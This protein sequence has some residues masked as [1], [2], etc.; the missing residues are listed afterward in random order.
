MNAEK[1]EKLLI[2]LGACSGAQKWAKGKTLAE[3]W[4]QC[5]RIDWMFWLFGKMEGKEGWPD[6]KA[7]VLAACSFA[8]LALS[9]VK[10]G[11]EHPREV[12][13]ITRA[14]IKGKAT[15]EEVAVA[16]DANAYAATAEYAAAFAASSSSSA[17][18]ASAAAASSSSSSAAAA[19]AAYA[20]YAADAASAAAYAAAY[21]ATIDYA[22]ADAAADA[23][24]ADIK[25]KCIKIIRTELRPQCI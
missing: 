8:E 1:V 5:E 24:D 2:S 3:M 18:A 11:E 22:A 17:A 12:I 21:A 14:W 25:I 13:D 9:F 15:I 20:A 4:D 7:I 6:R 10:A 19:S 23:A 16:H